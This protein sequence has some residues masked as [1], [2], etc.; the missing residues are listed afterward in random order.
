MYKVTVNG[1]DDYSDSLT[2]IRLAENGCY[3]PC[4]LEEAEGVCVRLPITVTQT[5]EDGTETQVIIPSETVFRTTG[6]LHGTEPQAT[7]EKI[8]GSVLLDAAQKS[9]DALSEAKDQ[10]QTQLTAMTAA[11]D[12]LQSKLDA[13]PWDY[14]KLLDICNK[15]NASSVIKKMLGL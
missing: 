15:I 7:I 13:L 9:R 6:K 2:P 12:E 8:E 10:I 3:V 1:T 11:R 4:S 5:A 14:T